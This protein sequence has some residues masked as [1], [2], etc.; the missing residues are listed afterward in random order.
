MINKKNKLFVFLLT[1]TLL[2]SSAFA[3][4]PPS[5]LKASANLKTDAVDIGWEAV[6]D[7]VGYNVYRKEATDQVYSKINASPVSKLSYHDRRVRTGGDY[8]YVIRSVFADGTESADSIAI[9]APLMAIETAASITT[10]RDKPL[11]ARSIKTGQIKTFAGPGDVITYRIS[12]AN[13]GYS[14]AKN[15]KIKYKIPDGTNIAGTPLVKKGAVALISYFDK[16][17]KKWI[18]Q[19]DKEENVGMVSFLIKNDIP[20]TVSSRDNGIIDLNVTIEL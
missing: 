14:S 7:A 4:Y 18:S 6:K 13:R 8:V 19:I 15:V 9:G 1:L 12:Y 17:S 5:N 3:I 16:V 2:A 11:T 20:P 10:L